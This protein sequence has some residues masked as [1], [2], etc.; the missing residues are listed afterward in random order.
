[1]MKLEKLNRYKKRA[2]ELGV[3]L[4]AYLLLMVIS[5]LEDIDIDMGGYSD[6]GA[7]YDDIL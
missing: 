3:S 5:K 2:K 7:P 1:M 4:E 6:G